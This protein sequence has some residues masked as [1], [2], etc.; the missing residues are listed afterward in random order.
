ML[1]R[2]EAKL[3]GTVAGFQSDGHLEVST[4][5][6]SN[7]ANGTRSW[8]DFKRLVDLPVLGASTWR[9][10]GAYRYRTWNGTLGEQ[11]IYSA[12]GT[13]LERR[14]DLAPWGKLS[15]N[16]FWRTGFGNFQGNDFT[17]NNLADFW[18]F[19]G[20][21]SVNQIGRAHV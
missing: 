16:Y 19:S 5:N 10:F 7:I 11:D 2:S 4:F 1:F 8:G 17:S 6:P 13:S 3:R 21:G 12:Y 9:L 14:G 15:G 18:R 20:I